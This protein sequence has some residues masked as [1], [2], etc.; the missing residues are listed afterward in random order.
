MADIIGA[1]GVF[2]ILLAY[3]LTIF[4]KLENTSSLYF[5]LN[6]VGAALA[7]I[8]S[9]LIQSIPFTVLEGTWAIVSLFALF[10]KK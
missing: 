10:Q 9:I 3:F 6:V 5:S 8:S 4:K 1:I 2:L 7:C